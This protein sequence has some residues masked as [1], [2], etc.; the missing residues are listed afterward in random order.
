MQKKLTILFCAL[1]LLCFQQI[2]AQ[3]KIVTG[4]VTSKT[5]NQPLPGVSVLI[6]GTTQGTDTD[7]DGNYS[8]NVPDSEGTTLTFSYMGM[9]TQSITI[10]NAS[11]YDVIMEEDSNTLDEVIVTA[12][13]IKRE[14]KALGYSASSVKGVELARS[15]ALN[16]ANALSGKAPGVFITNPSS[17]EGGS[18]RITLRGNTSLSGGNTP[19]IIVDGM[20]FDNT[21]DADNPGS[22]RDYGSG[23]NQIEA[24]DIQSMDILKGTAASALYGSR[25]A[26]GVIIITT[27]KGENAKGF[28]VEYTVNSKI[29]TPYRYQEFQNEYG[30]GGPGG[31][32]GAL[33][34]KPTLGSVHPNIWGDGYGAVP[35]VNPANGNSLSSWSYSQF[36]WYGTNSSWGPKFDNSTITWWDGEQRQ[37]SAQPDNM[38]I[39]YKDGSTTT[40][41]LSLSSNGKFGNV[42]TSFTMKDNDAIV[43]NSGFETININIGANLN[44]G[45]NLKAEVSANFNKRELK[46]PP[47]LGQTNS[48]LTNLFYNLP[49]SYKGLEWSNYKNPDGSRNNQS[50]WGYWLSSQNGWDF[51]ENEYT[52]DLTQMRMYSRLLFTP[53]DWLSLSTSV[54]LDLTLD[55][56]EKKNGFIDA[57]GLIGGKYSHSLNT[58]YSPNLEF[59][60]TI[61]KD[62]ILEGVNASLSFGGQSWS[63]S[64]YEIRGE[65]NKNQKLPYIYSFA[66]FSSDPNTNQALP[67]ESRYDK[68]INSLFG[69]LD[70]SYKDFLYLQATV[71]NDWSST[72]PAANN[73]YLYP[74]ASLSFIASE[75]IDLGDAVS[76]AKFR[77]A[78]AETGSDTDPYQVTPTFSPG[79]FGGS[80]TISMKD[81]LPNVGLKSQRSAEIEIGTNWSFLKNK[82]NVDLTYYKKNSFDQILSA[83]LPWSSGANTIKFNTGELEL[84][85]FE[86]NVNLNVISKE[87]LRLDVGFNGSKFSNK[88]LELTEGVDVYTI[89]GLWGAF[90][91]TMKATV[92]QEFGAI[93]GWGIQKAPNGRP[94]LNT[95]NDANGNVTSTLYRKSAEQEIV[96]NATP[97]MIGGFNSTLTWKNFRLFTLVDYKWGGDVY[98]PQYGSALIGGLSPATLKERNGG[99]LPFTYPS[100][101]TD[102]IGVIL[103]GVVETSPGVFVENTNVVHPYYKYA[104]NGWNP[105]PQPQAIMENSWV[106]LR[107]L[108]LS[109]NLPESVMTKLSF[110]DNIDLTLVGRDLFYIYDT[111]PDKI[112]PEGLNG[113]S[114]AQYVI[115][116]A[117]PV[118]RSF[119]FILK[120]TF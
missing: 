66:N 5:D 45:A 39:G 93:Y 85:G 80:P 53:T 108:S 79:S 92:G 51:N 74:G 67:R 68:K 21:S 110:I 65:N 78:Y 97:K 71:R 19:L 8:I 33:W 117:L 81:G 43:I 104:G 16:L 36:S 56:R 12:L 49:R 46:N 58:K 84:T 86:W 91:T 94:I 103:D 59:L 72:L 77:L 107:E 54:G 9:T 48:S 57:V 118:S 32:N 17:V 119:A 4:K 62:E 101:E 64:Q 114:D 14:A 99:G 102:N 31:A 100:G 7:F 120:A 61:H 42:R 52:Q 24:M 2:N 18:T 44:L 69:L 98:N 40:H 87:D 55:E 37:W 109:Y 60:A 11:T 112:N 23:L 1:S 3:S 116:G 25:G 38:K 96:G 113:I 30:Y 22:N 6:K 83:P 106:K 75:V 70:I 26:N 95:L 29:T 88:L 20:P 27:K 35:G 50:G 76:F 28:Q 13:G 82:I 10:G 41:N 115:A 47:L 90:G 73:D 15:G 89:G 105:N 34:K 111:M 63:K